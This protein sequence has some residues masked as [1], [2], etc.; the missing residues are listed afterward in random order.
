ML[1]TV[2]PLGQ[3][4]RLTVFAYDIGSARRA[5]RVRR[6]LDPLRQAKQY[7][8]YETMLN[9]GEFRGLLAEL[10]ECCDLATDRLAVWWPRRALRLEWR[11]ASLRPVALDG[12]SVPGRAGAV[13]EGG[14]FIVCYD[15]SD[16]DALAAAAALIGAEGAMVQ[17]SVYWLRVPGRRLVAV[18]RRAGG[19]LG[20]D[21]RLWAYPLR[22]ADELWRIGTERSSLLPVA[23]DHFARIAQ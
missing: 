20:G 7:S 16:P 13:P 22:G 9:R 23:A 19:R 6:L 8:V 12:A 10:T 3:P 14:N 17:R 5:R 18:L 11:D 2:A 1:L 21:D 15:I 4:P